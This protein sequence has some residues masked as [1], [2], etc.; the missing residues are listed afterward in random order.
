MS[1]VKW[2]EYGEFM[3]ALHCNDT[4]H[5]MCHKR[6][7]VSRVSIVTK[8]NQRVTNA[9]HVKPS[10]IFNVSRRTTTM[11]PLED[12][13]NIFC[14]F[15]SLFFGFVY[16][17]TK[18]T[19]RNEAMNMEAWN[20]NILSWL[21]TRQMMSFKIQAR[22]DSVAQKGSKSFVRLLILRKRITRNAIDSVKGLVTCTVSQCQLANA[23]TRT[24]STYS[25][26]YRFL[27]ILCARDILTIV[28]LSV[29]SSK[30]P[31]VK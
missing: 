20:G 2:V 10:S 7:I 3:H 30:C 8:G 9:K 11:T 12:S 26:L 6:T 18:T 24:Y 15:F 22:H 4:R 29:A 23:S 14:V 1:A 31:D 27:E 16:F 17:C 19:I 25:R 5:A 28:C 13:N 21:W